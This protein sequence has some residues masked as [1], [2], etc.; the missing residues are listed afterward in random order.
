MNFGLR[1]EDMCLAEENKKFCRRGEWRKKIQIRKENKWGSKKPSL[2]TILSF[3][4]LL[5]ISLLRRSGC[6]AGF[7][8]SEPH[9]LMN[10]SFFS[11]S[12]FSRYSSLVSNLQ[13]Q[14]C[15]RTEVGYF[16]FFYKSRY[17][18]S[19]VP[20]LP[21]PCLFVCLCACAMIL[22][23]MGIMHQFTLVTF[24]FYIFWRFWCFDICHQKHLVP[25]NE[26]LQNVIMPWK[27]VTVSF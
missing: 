7:R 17:L 22:W 21:A 15:T 25:R 19:K 4:V 16:A 27:G 9:I 8:Q 1:R 14:K 18:T 24:L 11:C 23:T 10:F 5:L 20:P 26:L 6:G 3:L 13:E 12:S 2:S